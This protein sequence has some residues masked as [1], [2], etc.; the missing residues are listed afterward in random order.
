MTA[1]RH[2]GTGGDLLTAAL[3]M[4]A[5]M[6]REE[7]VTALLRQGLNLCM[8][9]LDCERGLL[10]A[11]APDG[12]REIICSKGAGEPEESSYSTTALG[13]VKEKG[14]PLLISDTIGNEHLGTR[15]S[16]SGG[17]IRSVLCTMLGAARET[18]PDRD[19]YLYLDSRTDRRPMSEGDLEK[20]RLLAT[21]M[22]SL[23]R[24]ADTTARQEAAIEELRGRVE[25]RRFED[26]LFS[27]DAFGRCV[28]LVKQAAPADVPILLVGETGTGKEVLA[29][30]AHK[31]SPRRDGP[32]LAVNCGALPPTL[33]ESQLF[34]HE[35]GAF[36]GA[37]SAR[38]GY[39]RE[40]SGGTL[41]L[42]EVGEL[43][44]QTQA[45]FLRVLQE[46][47]VVAV[48]ATRPEKVD[49]RVVSA[50]NA[51]L[52]KGV[53]QGTFRKDL[54]FRLNVVPVNVPPVRERG[55]DALLLAR[56]FL[57]RHA[58]SSG[59]AFSLS[60]E[61]EKAIL[62]Y[63][64]PGNVREIQNR[65]QRAVI[66]SSSSTLSADSLDLAR[67]ETPGYTSLPEARE[68]VDREMIARALGRAPG[69]LTGAAKILGIDRKSLRILLEKY[70]IEVSR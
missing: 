50:T 25:E 33:M 20:F 26:L 61:A 65:I 54:F 11:E 14:E 6:A 30:L 47:E 18:F 5:S 4:T 37:V 23:V 55:E 36:T 62:R 64:W 60:R 35:K 3:R 22:G 52:D 28:E 38:K 12:R 46:G 67:N 39:F 69:N 19:I 48:G 24:R 15:E 56:F 40:A 45:Q 42:D 43:P 1:D 34:G 17:N 49:V 53:E 68:A 29:R 32:F 41:F 27:G 10:I 16:I 8:E 21:L 9:V 57:S 70:G 31:L 13:M 2:H 66:T 58:E 44:A 63:H 7:G 51:D 59:R